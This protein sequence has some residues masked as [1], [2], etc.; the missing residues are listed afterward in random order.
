MLPGRPTVRSVH[1][2]L[3]VDHVL[4]PS[5]VTEDVHG[6]GHDQR[7][8]P[9]LPHRPILRVC[10]PIRI[11]VG[12]RRWNAAGAVRRLVERPSGILGPAHAVRRECHAEP[13]VLTR[14]VRDPIV[15]GHLVPPG[16]VGLVGVHEDGVAVPVA[17][18]AAPDQDDVRLRVVLEREQVELRLGEGEPVV[19]LGV[20]DHAL[21]PLVPGPLPGVSLVPELVLAGPRVAID[22]GP[23]DRHLPRLRL[24]DQ[25]RL[26]VPPGR[27]E[28]PERPRA[29]EDVVVVHEH[30]GP[31]PG[32]RRLRARVLGPGRDRKGADGGQDRQC[33]ERSDSSA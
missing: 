33:G 26:R 24:A 30:Q 22:R 3:R 7:V 32:R 1:P 15:V 27:V 8:E 29:V 31:V 11:F 12:E 4:A 16:R 28:H 20:T 13:G 17:V 23:A 9:R 2:H 21:E 6:V 25:G 5:R 10:L 14:S 19:G 18:P